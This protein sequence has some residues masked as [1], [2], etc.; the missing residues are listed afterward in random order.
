MRCKRV[1]CAACCTRLAGVNHCRGCLETL[2]ARSE[3]PRRTVG[4]GTVAALLV[5]GCAWL[6]LFGVAWLLEGRLAP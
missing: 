1:I 2:A 3:E 5:L 4:F 6:V